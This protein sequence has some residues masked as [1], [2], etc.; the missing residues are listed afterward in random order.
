MCT[1]RKMENCFHV[2]FLAARLSILPKPFP[3]CLNIVKCQKQ[4]LIKFC[5]N[6]DSD[7]MFICNK[8][9]GLGF[10]NRIVT[11]LYNRVQQ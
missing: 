7:N 5:I 1:L 11:G 6:I 8:K 3:F 4:K 10:S 2:V 9:Q